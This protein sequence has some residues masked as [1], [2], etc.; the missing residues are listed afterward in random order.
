[1]FSE[2]LS[3]AIE[4]APAVAVLLWLEY[5]H[6]RERANEREYF[7]WL[8]S[9]CWREVLESDGEGDNRGQ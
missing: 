1:M 4:F 5:I 7:Q 9:E 2:L 3:K 8:L 6:Q